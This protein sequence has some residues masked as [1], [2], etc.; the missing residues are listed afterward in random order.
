[1][2]LP[3][4]AGDSVVGVGVRTAAYRDDGAATDVLAAEDV[5]CLR[6]G[7]IFMYSEEAVASGDPVYFRH[8]SKG[9]NTVLGRVR[10]DADGTA[11]V[12]TITPTAVNDTDY[13][14][15]VRIGTADYQFM[16]T[17]DGSATATEICDGLRTAMAL[18]AGFTAAVTAS[19]TATL[20]LTAAT[21]GVNLVVTSNGPGALAIVET[22]GPAP[23]CDLLAGARFIETTS[24]AGLARVALNLP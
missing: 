14:L 17:S 24:T 3:S 4:A 18:D 21:A 10:N 2:L 23:T 5:A 9:G 7:E 16:Y 20:I 15:N 8:T 19:G 22:T 1:M 13:A 6:Q 11:E 12:S